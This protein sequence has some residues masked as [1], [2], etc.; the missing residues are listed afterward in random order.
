MSIALKH[1]NLDTDNSKLLLLANQSSCTN[2][3]EMAK[4]RRHERSVDGGANTR[5]N[6]GN[7][8]DDSQSLPKAMINNKEMNK[9][10]GSIYN[11]KCKVVLTGEND[12][13]SVD[14]ER[15]K[16][17]QKKQLRT[18]KENMKV[19]SRKRYLET[20]KE[21]EEKIMELNNESDDYSDDDSKNFMGT[22][23]NSALREIGS[24]PD[25]VIKQRNRKGV[26]TVHEDIPIRSFVHRL[27]GTGSGSD[28]QM[29]RLVNEEGSGKKQ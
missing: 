21:N 11:N 26:S 5:K 8:Q 28:S 17:F 13:D 22:C 29:K 3:D 25:E 10:N 24:T 23:D 19:A 9:E 20:V 1:T 15:T 7:V 18:S 6:R 16:R 14:S 4:P 12:D 2:L 27:H